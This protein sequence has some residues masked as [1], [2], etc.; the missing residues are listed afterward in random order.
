LP[1]AVP[2]NSQTIAI[3]TFTVVN[4]VIDVAVS[5]FR[6]VEFLCSPN[7]FFCE[8]DLAPIPGINCF[9]DDRICQFGFSFFVEEVRG[10]GIIDVP[11]S[12][13]GAVTYSLVPS[14]SAVPGPLAGTGIP[15]LLAGIFGLLGLHKLRRRSSVGRPPGWCRK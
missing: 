4:G 8:L 6:N 13:G 12:T 2:T 14:P 11:P 15:G 1:I 7:G 5:R 10:G 9:P 3:N